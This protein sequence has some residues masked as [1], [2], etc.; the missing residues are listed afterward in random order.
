MD[1]CKRIN[2]CIDCGK[3]I[4][5]RGRPKRCLP[6]HN[7]FIA[8]L[9]YG[10][11]KEKIGTKHGRLLI[12]SI[13]NIKGKSFYRCHCDCGTEK[14][15]PPANLKRTFSCGCL[16]SELAKKR[17]TTHGMRRTA[18]Y[19]IWSNILSRCT[20]KHVKK[21]PIYGGR[22]ITVCD[23]WLKFENFHA[24]MGPRPSPKHSIDRIK[25][26]QGYNKDNCRWALDV[27]QANN[28]RDNRMLEYKGKKQS[29]A[30]WAREIGINYDTLKSRINRGWSFEKAI[31]GTK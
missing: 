23:R 15:I 20:N 10:D 5:S 28:R 31:G 16:N 24:D 19:R 1:R 6:C 14:I 2:R 21:Y 3:E 26:E 13:I 17:M 4:S 11:P 29:L 8:I 27:I 22:G 12:L 25:N 7:R 18:E 30:L 9:K